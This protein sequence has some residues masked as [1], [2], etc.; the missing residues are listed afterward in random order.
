MKKKE[1]EKKKYRKQKIDTYA[2]VE[3]IARLKLICEKYGINSIYKLLQYLVYC[4]L[5]VADPQNDPID[6]VLPIEIEEMFT[7]NAEWERHKHSKGS[8]AGMNIRKK[9]DQRKFKTPDDIN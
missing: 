8:H 5:R 9:Q 4:F 1:V 3:D 2:S 6:E 7:D